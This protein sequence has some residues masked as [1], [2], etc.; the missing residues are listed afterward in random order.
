[1]TA[2]FNR[3]CNFF[4][5]MAIGCC[6]VQLFF[7]R[8]F[9]LVPGPGLD[10][11]FFLTLHFSVSIGTAIL[12]PPQAKPCCLSRHLRQAPSDCLRA[13]PFSPLRNVSPSTSNLDSS[14][15]PPP[16]PRNPPGIVGYIHSPHPSS[17]VNSPSDA[18]PFR[19][20]R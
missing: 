19:A 7:R 6:A 13:L 4:K 1:M 2:S 11:T 17:P 18:I 20:Q 10:P 5:R 9:S 16:R 15:P 14:R 8:I 12:I 3:D